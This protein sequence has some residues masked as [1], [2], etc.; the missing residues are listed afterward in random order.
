[1]CKVLQLVAAI[2]SVVGFTDTVAKVQM[3]DQL[4]VCLVPVIYIYLR[5]PSA[6]R[7]QTCLLAEAYAI[8]L[9]SSIF[10]ASPSWQASVQS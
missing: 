9:R 10:E 8:H 7:P 5:A 4:A 2:L 1:M 3:H 6:F